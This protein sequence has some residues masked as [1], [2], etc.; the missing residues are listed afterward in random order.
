M[1]AGEDDPPP[2]GTCDCDD[3]ILLTEDGSD[4]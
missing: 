4:G 1:P 3:T 2:D